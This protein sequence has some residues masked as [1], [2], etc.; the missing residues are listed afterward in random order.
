MNRS[1]YNRAG[2]EQVMNYCNDTEYES[3]MS[4]VPLFE[5]MLIQ[6][7]TQ[8]FKYYLDITKAEQEQ[9]LTDRRVNPLKQWKVSDVDQVA[10][11]HWND[12]SLA[13]NKMFARTHTLN[14]PWYVV[15]SDNKKKARLNVIRHI[16]SSVDCPDKDQH[17]PA[18]DPQLIFA[19]DEKH[20][21]SG[22]I[23]P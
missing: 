8:L 19:Y 23:A 1:W 15:Q 18:A 16:L 5:D 17:M 12:Y 2:V 11:E 7:G 3:F 13:R 22:A 20:L 6:S 21:K 9:R 4:S 10:V 14:A